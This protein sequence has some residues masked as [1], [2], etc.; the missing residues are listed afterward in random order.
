MARTVNP[1]LPPAAGKNSLFDDYRMAAFRLI[2]TTARCR[3]DKQS[4]ISHRDYTVRRANS[5]TL[6]PITAS[7]AK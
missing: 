6:K 5:F 1:L 7:A 3:L 4:A 2:Q